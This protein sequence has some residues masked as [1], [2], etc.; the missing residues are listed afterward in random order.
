MRSIITYLKFNFGFKVKKYKLRYY[1]D[2]FLQFKWQKFLYTF[3][4]LSHL[5]TKARM[6]LW[7]KVCKTPTEYIL[8]YPLMKCRI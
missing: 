2:C 8:D 6:C 4:K 7:D 3:F 1:H 5:K